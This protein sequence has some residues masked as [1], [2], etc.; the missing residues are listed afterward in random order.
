[1]NILLT[2]ASFAA[3]YGGPAYSVPRLA[4]ALAAQ[5]HGVGVW[6]AD[7]TAEIA[8][9]IPTDAPVR[10][11]AG[12]P[13]AALAAFGKPDIL[14]DNGLW[15]PHNHRL[16]ALAA[17]HGIARVVSIRGM[18]EP[19]A[20][21]H[22]H[23]KKRLAWLVYQ[24]RDLTR[25]NSLHVT[26]DSEGHALAPLKLGVRIDVIPNGI[27]LP[28]RRER[29]IDAGDGTRTALYL[30]R[31]HPKKGLPMLIAAWARLRP[32]GWRLVIAGPDE[33]GHRAEV[34]RAVAEARLDSAVVFP[35]PVEGDAKRAAFEAADLFVL[36]SYSENFGI[37]VAEALAHGVPVLTTRGTPWAGLE[38]RRC[39]WWVEATT[40][41]LHAGLQAA[42]ACSA[43]TRRDMGA[44][45][46]EFVSERFDWA[47][48]AARFAALYEELLQGAV[49]ARMGER[50]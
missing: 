33:A 38:E 24:R 22:R 18:L 41:G 46:R 23:W 48:V 29:A 28:R 27:D 20:M 32:D 17:E 30:G 47:H 8:A 42:I 26:A 10:R 15:R 7:G 31:I 13:Q 9:A 4:A 25:A 14:H 37:V 39:G 5:G 36:P 40:E 43:E 16:A 19:W 1:M 50:M 6:A 2:G 34:M 49:A 45:G 12:S 35:G 44:R 21:A 3:H 11:L